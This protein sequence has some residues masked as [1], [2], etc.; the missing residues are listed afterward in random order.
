MAIL[1][2]ISYTKSNREEVLPLLKD[3]V[4]LESLGMAKKAYEAVKDIW[5]DDGLPSDEGLRNA[6]ARAGLPSS[7]APEKIVNWSLLMKVQD[8]PRR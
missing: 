2:G 8:L 1:K 5:P 3:F 4:G 7:V 6:F